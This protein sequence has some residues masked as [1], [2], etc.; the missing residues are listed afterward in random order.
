[1]T[2]PFITSVRVETKGAHDHVSVWVQG[3]LT[4]TLVV[5]A[6]QG[7]QLRQRLLDGSCKAWLDPLMT[8][9]LIASAL[10]G[11]G[12]LQDKLETIAEKL[13]QAVALAAAQ[14]TALRAAEKRAAE[15]EAK[16]RQVD[17]ADRGGR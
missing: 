6:D 1:M 17:D 7:E 2:E 16:L 11:Q 9:E 3:A 15:A 4:G 8:Q 13:E 5:G 12:T 10:F 14:H